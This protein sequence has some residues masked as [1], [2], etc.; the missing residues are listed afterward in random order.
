MQN[1]DRERGICEVLQ[2]KILLEA[3]NYEVKANLSF[4]RK[5]S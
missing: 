5:L 3:G 2:I 1:P 4:N